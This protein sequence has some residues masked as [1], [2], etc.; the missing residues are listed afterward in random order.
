MSYRSWIKG[1]ALTVA[2]A[3][4]AVLTPSAARAQNLPSGNNIL[5]VLAADAEYGFD[6]VRNEVAAA[7]RRVYNARNSGTA[8][9]NREVARSRPLIQRAA[10]YGSS[11]YL[12]DFVSDLSI[13]SFVNNTSDFDQIIED[14]TFI[15]EPEVS[16]IYAGATRGRRDLA[17]YALRARTSAP[18]VN[19]VIGTFDVRVEN[20]RGG[21]RSSTPIARVQL[22]SDFTV[23][24]NLDTV[25]T[26]SLLQPARA[27]AFSR[28]FTSSTVPLRGYRWY[29]ANARIYIVGPN[30][31]GSGPINVRT[32]SQFVV[33]TLDLM[34]EL[35]RM[36]A[37]NPI[38]DPVASSVRPS[39]AVAQATMQSWALRFTRV[40]P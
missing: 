28:V 2:V 5:R 27:T 21:L 11:N 25:A 32:S 10:N 8:A 23:Q 15:A 35:G 6:T 30:S 22:M 16:S 3:L 14:L 36:I 40:T 24:G 9:I 18:I 38:D 26:A 7:T 31:A 37:A 34:P 1:V 20:A 4:A 29:I 19:A 17:D 39:L 13:F 12:D 33:R